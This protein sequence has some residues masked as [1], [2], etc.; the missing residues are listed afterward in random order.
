MDE[1]EVCVCVHMTDALN[2]SVLVLSPPNAVDAR[3]NGRPILVKLIIIQVMRCVM[4]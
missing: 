3:S 4:V 2:G 1:N